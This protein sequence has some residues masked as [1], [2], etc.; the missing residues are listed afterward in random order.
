MFS[1][2]TNIK[3][4]T[5]YSYI[6]SAILNYNK[7]KISFRWLVLEKKRIYMDRNLLRHAKYDNMNAR[8]MSR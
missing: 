3:P 6:L 2:I 7:P 5:C 4:N 8:K 1:K